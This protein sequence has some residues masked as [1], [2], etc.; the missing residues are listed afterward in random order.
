[1]WRIIF[2]P[3]WICERLQF[4]TLSNVFVWSANQSVI[5]PSLPTVGPLYWTNESSYHDELRA[6][7][8]PACI[9]GA[10]ISIIQAGAIR[11]AEKAEPLVYRLAASWLAI[12][13][14]FAGAVYVSLKNCAGAG[15]GSLYSVSNTI[16]LYYLGRQYLQKS[17]EQLLIWWEG[18]RV[19]CASWKLAMVRTLRGCSLSIRC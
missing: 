13:T 7:R 9:S 6:D 18:W 17:Q 8:L 2:W 15:A 10:P 5:P 19:R 14:F 16:R 11:V 4:K 3:C 12:F 1:M